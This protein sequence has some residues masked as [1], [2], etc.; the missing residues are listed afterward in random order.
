MT[1]DRYLSGDD[2]SEQALAEAARRHLPAGTKTNQSTINRIR[3]R[4]RTAGL[5]LALAIERA[6]DGKVR[7]ESLKLSPEDRRLLR[8]VRS[9]CFQAVPP[10]KDAAA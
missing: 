8:E 9:G 6:T 4:E 7:A 1:L 2:V 3:H 10:E 5:A